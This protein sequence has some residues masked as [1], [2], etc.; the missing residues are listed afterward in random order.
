MAWTYRLSLANRIERGR[1]VGNL[2]GVSACFDGSHRYYVLEP[3]VSEER[4]IAL[5]DRL[6][7]TRTPRSCYGNWNP[8][9][10]ECRRPET[11]TDVCSNSRFDAWAQDVIAE[12]LDCDAILA[13]PAPDPFASNVCSHR[14]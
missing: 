3:Q 8:R 14:P 2:Y 5:R 4:A 13:G 1:A 9:A 10:G 7:G 11:G 6:T 12:R